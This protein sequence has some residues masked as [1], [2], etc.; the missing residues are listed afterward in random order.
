MH[1]DLPAFSRFPLAREH[2]RSA[3]IIAETDLFI[4]KLDVTIFKSQAQ[5]QKFLDDDLTSIISRG[6]TFMHATFLKLKVSTTHRYPG[7]AI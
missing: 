5:R 3:E 1:P 7:W 2:A 4:S 6:R